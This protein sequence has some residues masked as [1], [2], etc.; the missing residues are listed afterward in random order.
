MLT[1]PP[2]RPSLRAVT[3]PGRSACCLCGRPVRQAD[4]VR[5]FWGPRPCPRGHRHY[6]LELVPCCPD[7]SR[8][9]EERYRE[10]LARVASLASSDGETT[11]SG[12][13][14]AGSGPHRRRRERPRA[15]S[16]DK[17]PGRREVQASLF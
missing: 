10:R 3:L 5:P 6:P 16:R 12:G 11:E 15:R 9:E 1:A 8:D 4:L 2:H 13:A 14:Q 17:G 7:C